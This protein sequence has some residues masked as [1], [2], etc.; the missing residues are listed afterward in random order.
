M[1]QSRDPRL[2]FQLLSLIFLL[3]SVCWRGGKLLVALAALNLGANAFVVGALAAAYSFLPMLI[4][5]HV[6]RL[7]DRVGAKKPILW[8]GLLTAVAVILPVVDLNLT[9]L[10]LCPVVLGVGQLLIQVS[11]HNGVGAISS[12]AMRS[13]N[14]AKL[15]VGASIG[16]FI[17]PLVVGAAVDHFG[18]N[19]GFLVV[20]V[21]SGLI[22]VPVA[23]LSEQIGI[24]SRTDKEPGRERMVDLLNHAA[25]RR[26]I[27][28]AAV[29]TC[30]LELFTFYI[31]I[32][33]DSIGLSATMIGAILA[34][35]ATAAFVVRSVVTM[36]LRRY[37]E[38]SILTGS[39]FVGALSFA[40]IPVF[41]N[42]PVLFVASFLL[43]LSIGV[44]AP[45]TQSLAYTSAPDGRTGEAL[46]LRILVGKAMQVI[47][48][49]GFGSVGTAFGSAPVFYANAVILLAAGVVSFYDLNR[50]D[51]E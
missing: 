47:V 16:A 4:S 27:F 37:S 11:T 41:T 9:T 44:A 3:N 33:G 48:P 8:G 12:P 14:Y 23:L 46:G 28:V 39:L 30:G 18:L 35:R 43:G 22:F 17:S 1:T 2:P 50:R 24:R 26:S 32:Y 6:G 51:G 45:L 21:S 20:V 31:P 36:M 29:A 38:M 40:I 13:S 15:Q 42:A 34:A 10:L 25:L 49:L 19:A 7:T 5:I